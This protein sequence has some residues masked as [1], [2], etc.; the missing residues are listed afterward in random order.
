VSARADLV[1]NFT[2]EFSDVGQSYAGTG[3][4]RVSWQMG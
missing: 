1:G 4:L 3:G 2:G